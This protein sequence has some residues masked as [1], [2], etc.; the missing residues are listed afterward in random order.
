MELLT[1]IVNIT[2]LR[3]FS[4]FKVCIDEITSVKKHI[5]IVQTLRI[6]ELNS[7]KILNII[8]KRAIFGVVIKNVLN[9]RQRPLIC[10]NC[11]PMQ[12]VHR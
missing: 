4:C 1:V 12:G 8:A 9:S 10:I 5:T 3:N 11:K 2:N 6:T 7:Q